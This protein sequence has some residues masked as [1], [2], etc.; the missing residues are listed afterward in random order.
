MQKYTISLADKILK[1]RGLNEWAVKTF[2]KR[3]VKALYI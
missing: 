1:R 2:L 3:I